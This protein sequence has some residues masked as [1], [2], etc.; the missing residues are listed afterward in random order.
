[1]VLHGVLYTPRVSAEAVLLSETHQAPTL[2]SRHTEGNWNPFDP[3][4]IIK[5]IT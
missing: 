5:S 3:G 1:M 4:V 2:S